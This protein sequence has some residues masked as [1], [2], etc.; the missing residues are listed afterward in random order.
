MQDTF[1][2]YAFHNLHCVVHFVFRFIDFLDG[3]LVLYPR[4]YFKSQN[5]NSN[6]ARLV[7]MI[8]IVLASFITKKINCPFVKSCS[9][10]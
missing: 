10:D 8:I 1:S 2:W 9:I 3:D 4:R 7:T 5:S 6:S